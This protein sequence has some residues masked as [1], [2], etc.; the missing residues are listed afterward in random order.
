MA[1]R[2][3]QTLPRTTPTRVPESQTPQAKQQRRALKATT[4]SYAYN[5]RSRNNLRRGVK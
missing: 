1:A 3:V 5:N 4:T 2:K